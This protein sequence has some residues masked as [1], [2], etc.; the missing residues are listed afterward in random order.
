MPSSNPIHKVHH[1]HTAFNENVAQRK[2]ILRNLGVKANPLIRCAAT[3]VHD[4]YGLLTRIVADFKIIQGVN[5][6]ALVD[7]A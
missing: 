3:A 7:L 4:G 6:E 2:Y 5:L 1:F